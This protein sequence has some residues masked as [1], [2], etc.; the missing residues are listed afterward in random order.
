MRK[1]T[2]VL[3]IAL[4]G[5]VAASGCNTVHGVGQDMVVAGKGVE[6]LATEA[7]ASHHLRKGH[8]T[9]RTVDDDNDKKGGNLL[10]GK[11]H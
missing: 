2:I 1:K 8:V 3:T 11:N 5:A 6:K 4:T 7:E 9:V 10:G